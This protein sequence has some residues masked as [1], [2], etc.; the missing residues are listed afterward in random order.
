MG[1]GMVSDKICEDTIQPKIPQILHNLFDRSTQI[2][3]TFGILLKKAI[4]G[5]P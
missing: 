4:T 3:Q 5:R 1:L 2:G